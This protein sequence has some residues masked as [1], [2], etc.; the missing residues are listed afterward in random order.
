M[1]KIYMFYSIN[2][3]KNQENLAQMTIFLHFMC[4]FYRNTGIHGFCLNT[5]VPYNFILKEERSSNTTL[6]FHWNLGLILMEC[7][8]V[9]VFFI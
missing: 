5:H 1:R 2:P 4:F 7:F 8:C 3:N 9:F 6:S